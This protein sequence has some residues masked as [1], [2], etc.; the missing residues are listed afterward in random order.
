MNADLKKS[1][2]EMISKHSEE[3]KTLKEQYDEEKKIKVEKN[4]KLTT[5]CSENSQ[6][7]EDIHQKEIENIQ[8]DSKNEIL[9]TKNSEL[10]TKNSQLDNQNSTLEISNS[11][12]DTK[13]QLLVEEQSQL[14]DK[15][16]QLNDE[17]EKLNDENDYLD[18][19]LHI[20]NKLISLSDLA[21]KGVDDNIDDLKKRIDTTDNE[22]KILKYNL[23]KFLPDSGDYYKVSIIRNEMDMEKKDYAIER[24]RYYLEKNGMD[25]SADNIVRDFEEKYGGTWH[26]DIMLKKRYSYQGFF[27]NYFIAFTMGEFLVIIKRI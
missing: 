11:E 26:A 27:D 4:N 1:K 22:N 5:K 13:Q 24:T 20:K 8:L 15:N 12:L 10:D 23:K 17:N 7:I 6:L 14:N 2:E 18:S 9:S 21:I 25:Y 19:S 3:M 16:I